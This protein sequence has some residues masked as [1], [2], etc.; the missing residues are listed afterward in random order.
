LQEEQAV[1]LQYNTVYWSTTAK[2]RISTINIDQRQKYERKI[3]KKLVF[4]AFVNFKPMDRFRNR[5]DTTEF[6]GLVVFVTMV[7]VAITRNHIV[8][9]ANGKLNLDYTLQADGV[10]WLG[11]PVLD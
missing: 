1:S 4:N 9:T 7:F 5:S 6:K 3:E 11:K 8:L 10:D 2:G